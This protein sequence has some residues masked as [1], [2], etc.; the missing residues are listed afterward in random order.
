MYLATV[1]AEKQS[2]VHEMLWIILGL[3]VAAVVAAVVGR[4]LVRRGLREPFVVRLVNRASD[5]IVDTVKRPIT[6]A[7]LDEVAAVLQTGHYTRNIGAALAENR[8]E[9][10]AMVAEKIRD[11]PTA[12]RIYLMPFHDRFIEQ[13]SET[14]LRVILDVLADP[15]T[16]ELFSDVLRD[17]I[18]QIRQAVRA[19][20]D[21]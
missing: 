11:D 12:G 21:L 8:A 10:K 4:W 20:A 2:L 17:N 16:D 6:I 19:R 7:V 1:D 15:R 5:R 3:V 9:V 13:V 18:T 14:T